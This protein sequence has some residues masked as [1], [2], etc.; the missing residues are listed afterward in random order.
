[1]QLAA[2]HSGELL[3]GTTDFRVR[4]A[5]LVPVE[6]HRTGSKHCRK[7]KTRLHISNGGRVPTQLLLGVPLFH[8]QFL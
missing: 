6:G 7:T 8:C 1:M 3:I 4:L 2:N 5:K